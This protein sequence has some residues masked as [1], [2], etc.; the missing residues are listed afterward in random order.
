[1]I[2]SLSELSFS[3][4]EPH[5]SGLEHASLV[6]IKSVCSAKQQKSDLVTG[7]ICFYFLSEFSISGSEYGR[8][9]EFSVYD[10]CM[11]A[12]GHPCVCVCVCVCEQEYFKTF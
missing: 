7:I 8:K 3:G 4:N 9:L 12:C 10:M 6:I 2:C 11:G 5:I 1:M